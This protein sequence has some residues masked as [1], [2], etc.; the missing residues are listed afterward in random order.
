MRNAIFLSDISIHFRPGPRPT[1]PRFQFPLLAKVGLVEMA[2]SPEQEI[3]YGFTP[4]TEETKNEASEKL[5][6]K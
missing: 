2:N 5:A 3:N 4:D 6:R 1:E